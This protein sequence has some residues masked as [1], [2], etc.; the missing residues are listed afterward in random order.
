MSDV[1]IIG[2][3]CLFPGAPNLETFWRNVTSG[4]DAISDVPPSRWDPVFYDPT[5]MASDRLYCKRGGFVD[6]YARFDPARHGVMPVSAAGA[7]PDQ[8]LALEVATQAIADAG[9][10]DRS[11]AHARTGVI[12]GRGNYAGAG[13]TRLE[14]HVRAAE[15]LV[16]ALRGLLPEL[17]EEHLAQVR[18]EFQAALLQ[19]G[20]DAAIGLIPNLTASRIANRLDLQ[21]PAFTIDA[22]CASALVA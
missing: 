5:A 12:I 11:F 6:G 9:Y 2:M 18:A 16:T 10:V 20:A 1:A 19:G 21:G 8:L 7:E 17:P 13:R 4:I 15:Q 22:A 14:Q 3:A